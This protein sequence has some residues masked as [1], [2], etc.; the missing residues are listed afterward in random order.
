M[1][2]EHKIPKAVAENLAKYCQKVSSETERI[3]AE[4]FRE[5]LELI[6]KYADYF[7]SEP[8]SQKLD[9]RFELSDAD[10]G[11][12]KGGKSYGEEC[13]RFTVVCLRRNMSL[14]GFD[15]EGFE[16]DFNWYGKVA[17]LDCVIP[18]AVSLR[19]HIK[20]L[21]EAIR[22]N[23]EEM[24]QKEPSWIA[25]QMYEYYRRPNVV[26]ENKMRYVELRLYDDLGLAEGKSCDVRNKYKCPYGD[27]TNELIE[28]G[29]VAKF[30][31]RIV[32]WYDLHWNPSE[33]FRPSAAEMKWYHYDEPSII[34]VT[35]YE[36]I[37]KAIEDGRLKKII[38]E[39]KRYKEEH[40]G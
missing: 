10:L 39:H 14:E 1:S 34:D 17:C 35:S 15:A 31:W 37:L 38:E 19:E 33:I 30:V 13:E 21:E 40:K 22:K 16:E 4:I 7:F 18:D 28:S 27:Q 25:R 3:A 2:G 24:K 32:W 12:I 36:D 11:F 8:W 26:R 20:R 6:K 5:F 29:R 23:E 9:K